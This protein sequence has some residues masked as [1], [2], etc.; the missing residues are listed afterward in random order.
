MQ[1]EAKRFGW[2]KL[3]RRLNKLDPIAANRIHPNDPQRLQRALEV[4]QITG[5]TLTRIHELNREKTPPYKFINIVI[6]PENRVLLHERI[7][8]RFDSMLDLG[9]L[10]EVSILHRRQDLNKKLPAMRAVGYRQAWQYLDGEI[11]SLEMRQKSIIATR[12]LAKRQLTW[13]RQWTNAYRVSTE[14]NR[15]KN[16]LKP[17]LEA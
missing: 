1:L 2:Q 4:I 16:W 14:Q 5:E 11:N 10:D 8:Q 3:H 13:L 12:Q 7:E 9:F 17:Q 6:T 15:L